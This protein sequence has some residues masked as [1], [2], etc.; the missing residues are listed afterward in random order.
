VTRLRQAFRE[1]LTGPIRFT[2]FV[3]RGY[4]AI[5]FEGRIGLRAVFRAEMVTN[6]ASPVRRAPFREFALPVGIDFSGALK[7]A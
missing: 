5:R 7:V 3:E 1:L 6:V 4:R 2:P